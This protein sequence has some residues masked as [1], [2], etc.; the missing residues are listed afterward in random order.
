MTAVQG[1]IRGHHDI[2]E[3]HSEIS[4]GE[5]LFPCSD[6][7]IKSQDLTLDEGQSE[8]MNKEHLG[9]ILVVDDEESIRGFLASALD[10]LGY[11]VKEAADGRE[12]MVVFEEHGQNI[13]LVLL[14]LTMP[15]LGGEETFGE[16]RLMR[17]DIPV[18]LMS[19]Y[20]QDEVTG[21]F[22][23]KEITGF[24]QK[25]FSIDSLMHT[26]KECIA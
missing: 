8:K 14:D 23:D 5:L 12:A 1:I 18:V 16:L 11:D 26:L 25:P 24:L 6:N 22:A 17:A 4:G 21:L 13:N 3:I 20:T 7:T 2:I 9:T 15:K 10:H 19:G